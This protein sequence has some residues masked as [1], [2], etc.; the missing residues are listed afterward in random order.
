M[1]SALGCFQWGVLAYRS[2]RL[3]RA[4]EWLERAA[5]LEGGKNYWYQFLL[6]YLEDKAGYTE[7][8]FR[9][10]S[11][12]VALVAHDPALKPA[13]PWVLF[14][15]ARIFRRGRWD[16]AREDMNAALLELKDKPEATRVRLE[17]AYLFQQVGD[18]KCAKEH[19]ALVVA[20]DG[21][22]D[23][24]RAARLNT[25]NIDAESGAVERA[26]PG[27]RRSDP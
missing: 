27:V 19:Y 17:L 15:R 8:A 5:R 13:S 20:A 6:G 10:Y 9:N 3:S 25:A 2:G 7:D 1:Q 18:F 14:S 23:Y 21:S 16:W 24:A 11:V 26:A 4:I 22:G 12:A